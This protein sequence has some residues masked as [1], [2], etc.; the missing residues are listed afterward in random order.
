M[1]NNECQ[2]D[3]GTGTLSYAK[4]K[5]GPGIVVVVSYTKLPQ[6]RIHLCQPC[7]CRSQSPEQPA[8][9]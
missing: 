2:R 8:G 4:C 1:T 3:N 5:V 9:E 7:S 6:P